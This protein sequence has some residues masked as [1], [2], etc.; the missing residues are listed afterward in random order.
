MNATKHE[1][2]VLY[3][4]DKAEKAINATRRALGKKNEQAAAVKFAHVI[5]DMDGEREEIEDE[6]GRK[7]LDLLF[8]YYKVHAIRNKLHDVNL[9]ANEIA[10]E[11]YNEYKKLGGDFIE[12]EAYRTGKTVEEVKA[13]RREEKPRLLIKTRDEK[14]DAPEV[15]GETA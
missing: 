3:E 12:E 9:W 1:Y 5:L 2:Y 13:K 6:R 10:G 11:I 15:P 8:A 4:A 14:E 7:R